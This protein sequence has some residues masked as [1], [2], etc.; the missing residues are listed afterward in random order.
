HL[1]GLAV[2]M[3][4]SLPHPEGGVRSLAVACQEGFDGRVEVGVILD[5]VALACEDH[6]GGTR[7]CEDRGDG[8]VLVVPATC[9]DK[10]RHG[11]NE[12]WVDLVAPRRFQAREP[13]CDL[14]I[15]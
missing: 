15:L 5:P 10:G 7:L 12:G 9:E 14:L 3:D 11:T 1:L 13:R 8:L 2:L 6:R 4:T